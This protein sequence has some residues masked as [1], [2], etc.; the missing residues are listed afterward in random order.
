QLAPNDAISLTVWD[1]HADDTDYVVSWVGVVN[2]VRWPDMI[3]CQLT[4]Q[5]LSASFARPGLRRAW[6]LPCSNVLY[7]IDCR[8]VQALYSVP[9]TVD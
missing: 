5:S 6:Q 2:D 1:K 9:V 7:D 3:T 4:C 8:V